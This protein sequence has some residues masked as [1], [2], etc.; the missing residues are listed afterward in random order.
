MSDVIQNDPFADRE[1]ENY[2]NPIPSREFIL[3]F[4]EQAGVPMNRND[5]FEALQLKDEDQYE[6]LRRRLRAMERDGQLVFTRRQCYALPEKLEMIK[7]YVIGH[8][9]GHGWVRPEGSVNKDDDI[10]LPHHQMKTLIHGDFVLV[11]PTDN[12]KR[13]RREGRLVRVLDERKAQIVGRFFL[14]Y[15]YSYVVPDDS[16]ISH[17]ILIPNE[18]K[19]GARM[20]NVVVIEI[21]DRGARSRGMMGKVVEVLGE[22]MAPGMETQIAIRTHQ[23]PHEWPEEVDKQIANLGEEVPEEAKVGRVDLRQLPLVTIDGEDA[24][25]FDD[26]VYCEKKKSGG[27]RLWVAIADVSYYVR[28]DSALD[29]EAINRGNSVYFPSQV[30][31]MLPEVLSNG[32]CSLNPQVDRLCMVCEMTISDSGKLS[33]YKHYEAVMNSHARLTYTKVSQILEGDEELR[34]RYAPLVSHLE[35]LHAMYKVLKEARDQRGAIEFETVETKFIF[36]AERKIDRIEPVIRNDAHK[37]IEEC[38]I[39]ANIASA[40]L[41]EKAKEPAL[42]RIH[43]SPGELRLQGFRDFLGEL[44]LDL[45]GGLEPSPTDYADLVKQIGERADKELIQTMLLRSMKQAVYNADNAGHFG[46]ALQR[47]AHF[48]SPIRRYPDLLLHR[49]IKYLIAKEKGQNQDRW[50]PTGGFHYS[51]DDMD[52]YGEQCSMTERRADDAT[53]DVADWL[54]CEYM[55][56]HVGDELDGVIANVTSFGFF[57]RLTELHIDGLVHISTL[58]NDYYQFD[59]IGQRL[60]GESFG[61][62][63]RLGDAVK[64]KVLAVNLNDK[65]IDFE[66]VGTSRKLRGEGKTAKKRVAEAKEKAKAKKKGVARASKAPMRHEPVVEPTKRP[67]EKDDKKKKVKKA[68]KKKP[69]SKPKKAKRSKNAAE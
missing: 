44:G 41:V 45:K 66:L 59:P 39:M 61:H 10:L 51:F 15:G 38:M 28:P 20:G 32:L 29:K 54:K 34:E 47:Y 6:G 9:D 55:Q 12:S 24:R 43:E 37:I 69:H 17:D 60:I 63:Y 68:Q 18:H 22:N 35:E 23:I 31:P 53:R 4:L 50:T 48:T 49:A 25:D 21:T 40:S 57:V 2:E 62:I 67:E 46:L 16:R 14:E 26:A 52:F 65:Q 30:V 27:W 56:D 42:Y 5:L 33:G 19:A 36:N 1:S 58:A 11:Q 3:E 64:V 8:K 7:G 13:G